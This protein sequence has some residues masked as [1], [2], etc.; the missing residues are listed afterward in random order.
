MITFFSVLFLLITL[1]I[2]LVK[3]SA[4]GVENTEK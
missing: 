3:L 2:A 4:T 1:N